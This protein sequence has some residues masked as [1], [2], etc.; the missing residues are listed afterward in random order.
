MEVEDEERGIER[1]WGICRSSSWGS[2]GPE[3]LGEVRRRNKKREGER[4]GMSVRTGLSA[5]FPQGRLGRR[6]TSG[7]RETE[8]KGRL[9]DTE[10]R[11]EQK[12]QEGGGKLQQG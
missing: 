7:R 9:K 12:E 11:D 8:K 4:E 3:R 1:H 2:E 6:R 10:M 5:S